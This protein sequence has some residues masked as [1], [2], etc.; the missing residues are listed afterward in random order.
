MKHVLARLAATG[1]CLYF[2]CSGAATAA[3]DLSGGAGWL[4]T[5]DGLTA[6]QWYFGNVAPGSGIP[7][8]AP[9]GNSVTTALD[10]DKMMWYCDS[11][12]CATQAATGMG[13][14]ETYYVKQFTIGPDST[15]SGSFSI[16]ADDF[17]SVYIN[18]TFVFDAI[19]D[20]NQDPTLQPVPLVFDV[21]GFDL[22]LVS[23]IALDFGTLS[24]VLKPGTNTIVLQAMDGSLMDGFWDIDTCRALGGRAIPGNRCFDRHNREYEYVFVDGSLKLPEPASLALIGVGLAGVAT[25]MRRRR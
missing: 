17:V 21:S 12:D 23:G 15:V 14:E 20:S 18:Q 25:S 22:S 11:A 7:A 13:P 16:I 1:T 8:Y 4:S 19:L 10:Q 6:T 5:T 2:A 24:N 9:Y 3:I